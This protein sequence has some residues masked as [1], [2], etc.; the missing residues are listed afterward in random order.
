MVNLYRNIY[1]LLS[2]A[3]VSFLCSTTYG[4]NVGIGTAVPTAKLHVDGETRV[5]SSGA[6]ANVVGAGSIRWN[7]GV[8]QYS[9][10]V[11]WVNL[12]S[13]S[14]TGVTAS[15]PLASSG[16]VNPN[17][18]LTGVVPVANGGTGVG[19]IPVNALVL[20]NG[21]SPVN[22]LVPS[23][24]NTVLSWNG[25]AYTWTD[26]SGL[27]IRN[28]NAVDQTANFR[29]S[30]N[31]RLNG[32][33]HVSAGNTTGGG[34]NLS[35]DG[36][37][38][39]MND[40]YM[41]TRFSLGM[42]QTNTAYGGTVVN[43]LA[44]VAG[45]P[46]YFNAGNNFG[47]GT[48]TPGRRL[49]VEGASGIISRVSGVSLAVGNS[50]QL[51]LSNA[52]SG[53]VNISFHRE[54]VYGAHFGLDTDN[55]FSTQGWSAGSGYTNLRTGVVNSVG[56][57]F[58]INGVNAIFNNAND[59][60]GNIRVL[61]N[62]SSTL[63]D[64]MYINYNSTGGT[65]AHLRFYANGTTERMFINA[66]NGHVGIGTSNPQVLLAVGGPGANPYATSLWVENNAHIQ[67]NEGLVQGGRGRMRVGTAWGYVGLY[68]DQSSTSANNDLVLG[69]SSGWVRVGG[70]GS[71]QNIRVD[72]VV[73]GKIQDLGEWGGWNW[74]GGCNSADWIMTS[75]ATSN[76]FLTGVIGSMQGGGEG[77]YIYSNGTNWVLRVQTCRGANTMYGTARCV[78]R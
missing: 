23:G 26:G 65:N 37:I 16:G 70:N 45:N 25:S 59:I 38:V 32:N 9:D 17:I 46:V 56:N 77:T 67:G 58:Q 35:D 48:T 64:G 39:D 75:I 54:G 24:S 72:G 57:A 27:Y 51:E 34:I 3:S 61:Q 69:A 63:Q 60:Y 4:Q 28:Q 66:A 74:W 71:G 1:L 13:G 20:G 36:D 30:G 15:A 29:I 43:Q 6:A 11:S 7:A 18:S 14:V 42:R 78:G 55:W 19:T 31:G 76:C 33:L 21:T 47:I 10:G 62:N 44:A 8:L 49:H 50:S 52:A 53:A 12:G 2:T 5:G 68:A 41:T 22:T 73:A 40:G